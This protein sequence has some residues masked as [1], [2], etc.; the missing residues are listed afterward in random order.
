[1]NT[2]YITLG[3]IFM[4]LT[5]FLKAQNCE[6]WF[7][8]SVEPTDYHTVYFGESSYSEDSIT[9]WSWDF[10]DGNT[11]SGK[12]AEHTYNED[13]NYP[14]RLTITSANCSDTFTDSVY[15]GQQQIS[16][17]YADF[18][19][20]IS[21]ND[22]LTVNF[23]DNSY[24]IAGL[25]AWEWDF[26]DGE[27]SDLQNP[28][29]VYQT[30]TIYLVRLIV[31]QENLSDTIKQYVSTGSNFYLG[32]SCL[33]MF[34]F[35]QIDPAGYTFTFYDA[36]YIP[37]DTVQTYL[38]DFGDGVTSS[39]ANPTHSYDESDEYL[40]SLTV[41]SDTCETYFSEYIYAGDYNWYPN[42]CQPLFWFDIDNEDYMTYQFY[43]LSYG[44]SPLQSWLWDFGDGTYSTQ[45]N[46]RHQYSADGNYIVSLTLTNESCE[47]TFLMDITV[48]AANIPSD[49]LMP[50]FYPAVI[51]GTEVQF[52]NLTQGDADSYLWSFDN[53]AT[54]VLE[55]PVF[56]FDEP[57]I[58]EVAL[59]ARK[60]GS[61]NTVVITFEI[62][63][64]RKSILA[65]NLNIINSKFYAGDKSSI[66]YAENQDFKLFPNPAEHVIYLNTN[67]KQFDIQI[68]D[69]S[70]KL[71]LQSQTGNHTKIDISKLPE[72]IYIL[73]IIS[74]HNLQ[75]A[76]FV[77]LNR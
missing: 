9:S 6:A 45:Q 22:F 24:G 20:E 44:M 72:G 58:H 74:N 60:D 76:K 41:T 4:T 64:S 56:V 1:M 35:Q 15:I 8:T 52:Y 19:Y 46:P 55:H 50:M 57:G 3:L 65:D 18:F 32:D 34:S 69:I 31:R 26:G 59:S 33:A 7:Y 12:L 21:G 25:D 61:E 75:T 42:E 62:L 70:G 40:V 5:G 63:S 71:I 47:N 37:G 13:G 14:V 38:W 48:D 17:I 30:D 2:K 43:D 11:S 67:D 23:I 49:S 28:S 39:E 10:G 66:Q 51:Q 53:T 16:D 73:K 27:T 77:K 29:H 36:S 54:S 68:L